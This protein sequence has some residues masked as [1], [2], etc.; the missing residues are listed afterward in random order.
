MTAAI[1]REE[2]ERAIVRASMLERERDEAR[3]QRDT[4]HREIER[5]GLSGRALI[6]KAEAEAARM[7]LSLRNVL[8]MAMRMTR[9][10]Q[11]PETAAHLIRFCREAGVEPSIL[12]EGE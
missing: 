8:A 4:C 9:A 12:R 7:E 2:Y 11:L 5:L 3:S 10:S 6:D 1:W